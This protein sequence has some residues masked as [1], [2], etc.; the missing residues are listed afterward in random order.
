MSDP[1]DLPPGEPDPED[2]SAL[3]AEFALGLLEGAEA[4]AAQARIDTDPDF[5]RAVAE[6]QARFAEMAEADLP[7][8]APPERTKAAVEGRLF[9]PAADSATADTVVPLNPRVRYWRGLAAL[10]AAAALALAVA[11]VQ[12]SQ[13]PGRPDFVAQISGGADP[14]ALLITASVRAEEGTVSLTAQRAEAPAGRVLELWLIA[15]GA[16]APVSLGILPSA[17]RAVLSLDPQILA[18]LPGGT[19]AIS[20]EPPGGSPTGVPTG[21]VLGTGPL[22]PL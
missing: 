21:S 22:T 10:A 16:P 1:T 19:L 7:P 4:R 18:A 5:A 3:A 12:L 11:L 13:A 15:E 2:D 20:D 6:W 9:P 8:V 14:Q 17:E